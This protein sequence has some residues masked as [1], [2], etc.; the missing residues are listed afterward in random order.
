M[1]V[2]V[3]KRNLSKFEV[4]KYSSDLRLLFTELSSRT[5]GIKDLNSIARRKY[6]FGREDSENIDKYIHI[7][8]GCKHRIDE[9]TGFIEMHVR[10]ANTI[11]PENIDEYLS[12]R[13]NQNQAIINCELL[14]NELQYIVNIFDVDINKYKQ[15]IEAIDREI[16]LIKRW[17]QTDNKLKQLFNE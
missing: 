11:Y 12:R 13:D 10:A 17:R 1:S 5:F 6:A 15:Y 14:L 3:S 8:A 4:I 9:I 16:L 7:L 2:I